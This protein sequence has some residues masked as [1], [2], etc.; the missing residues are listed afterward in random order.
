MWVADNS[1]FSIWSMAM[2]YVN[3]V[4]Q[5]ASDCAF[6][7][8]NIRPV[9]VCIVG[10]CDNDYVFGLWVEIAALCGSSKRVFNVY[11][12]SC[13]RGACALVLIHV[14]APRSDGYFIGNGAVGDA[15]YSGICLDF[16][17]I[18]QEIGE[19][20]V[21]YHAVSGEDSVACYCGCCS[22]ISGHESCGCDGSCN[23]FSV[24]SHS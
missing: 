4:T 24:E 8:S 9:W 18:L 15:A 14:G 23:H 12:A 3:G 1:D 20:W 21:C 16:G 10:A 19:R 17:F 2:C 5:T 22:D 13:E 11:T 7:S 6:R